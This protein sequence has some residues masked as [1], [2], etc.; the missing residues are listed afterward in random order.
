MGI[1]LKIT[2]C[3]VSVPLSVRRCAMECVILPPV[4]AE[5]KSAWAVA[6]KSIRANLVPM[7]VLWLLAALTVWGYYCL[8][9]FSA[10]LEPLAEWQRETGWPAA[11]V[12]RTVFGGL[13]PGVF[14]LTVRSIRPPRPVLTVLA[15][16]LWMGSWGVLS[17]AFFT[18]QAQTFGNGTDFTTLLVKVLVDKGLWSACLCV[19]LNSLFFYWE[20]RDFSFAR[21]RREW[22]TSWLRQIY[23]PVLLADFAVW[24]PVQFAVY[25]FPL[26]LQ[27]QLVGFAGCFWSLVGLSAGIRL[28][29][30]RSAS[31]VSST[32]CDR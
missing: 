27:I 23:L 4:E 30:S 15:N 10:V 24:I 1:Y 32:M 9:S 11:V 8:S 17:N 13:L 20:G 2:C 19:P 21:C 22:P 12:N 25:M 18:L 7:A 3:L 26:P 14:L 28:A 16:C 5:A 31:A 6:L 29:K